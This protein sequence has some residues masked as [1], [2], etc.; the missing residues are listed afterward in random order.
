[1]FSTILKGA[2]ALIVENGVWFYIL[3]NVTSG[4]VILL[5]SKTYPSVFLNYIMLIMML[6]VTTE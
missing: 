5:I 1:M 3:K 6:K 2:F 4:N